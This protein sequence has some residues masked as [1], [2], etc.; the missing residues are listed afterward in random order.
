MFQWD[1]S[2][3]EAGKGVRKTIFWNWKKNH[4]VIF[5]HNT[6][7]GQDCIGFEFLT[8]FFG[9]C[10][11]SR[12][13]LAYISIKTLIKAD[14]PNFHFVIDSTMGSMAKIKKIRTAILIWV[15]DYGCEDSGQGKGTGTNQALLWWW[16]WYEWM[17][18]KYEVF[19][20]RGMVWSAVAVAHFSV[21][22]EAF[23][24]RLTD[25]DFSHRTITNLAAITTRDLEKG[26]N[27]IEKTKQRSLFYSYLFQKN[28]I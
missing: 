15:W 4:N 7:V 27:G 11:V 25:R 1:F 6:N 10:Y 12:S 14:W 23:G 28:Q 2:H 8:Y 18:D 5:T 22:V 9:T 13:L 19:H 20:G 16:N 24:A 26:E 3:V 21:K 17:V